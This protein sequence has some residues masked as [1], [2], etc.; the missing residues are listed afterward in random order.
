MKF[1][2]ILSIFLTI[3]IINLSTKTFAAQKEA[4][5]CKVKTLAKLIKLTI[6][7]PFFLTVT[8]EAK[9]NWS[10]EKKDFLFYKKFVVPKRSNVAIMVPSVLDDCEVWPLDIEF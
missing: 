4:T 7:N 1:L 6:Y 9:C 10:N 2:T 3:C 5:S 8:M